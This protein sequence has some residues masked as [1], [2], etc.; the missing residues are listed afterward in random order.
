MWPWKKKDK[1]DTVM[2][3]PDEVLAKYEKLMEKLTLASDFEV[4]RFDR[5]EAYI[6]ALVVLHPEVKEHPIVKD[7]SKR[8]EQHN[9]ILE[10][11]KSA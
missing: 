1:L 4:T 8:V 6:K 2:P 9:S 10:K 5:M 11:R 7:L 3:E